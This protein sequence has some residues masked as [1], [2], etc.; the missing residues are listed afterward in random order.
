MVYCSIAT[1]R[2]GCGGDANP[3]TRARPHAEPW[4]VHRHLDKVDEAKRQAGKI[5]LVF[6]GDSITQDY[7]RDEPGLDFKPVWNDFFAPHGAMN[8]GFKADETGQMLWRLRHGEVNGLAP[9]DVVILAGANNLNRIG[10][11]KRVQSA[12]QI[13]AGTMAVVQEVHSRM[14]AARILVLS[15]LPADLSAERAVKTLAVNAHVQEQVSHL[16]YARYLDVTGLFMDGTRVRTELY[17]DSRLQPGAGALHPDP[18]G[19]RMMAHAV[20]TAL[21]GQ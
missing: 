6:V 2:F 18:I 7:E 3:A 17:F 9:K 20:A 8:L 16:P 4:W 5:N 11:D 21:Y 1:T 19:Q 10:N 15:V 12:D 13:T 14:P